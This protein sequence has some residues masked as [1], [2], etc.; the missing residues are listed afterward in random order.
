MPT[1]PPRWISTPTGFLMVLRE[2]DDVFAQLEALMVR[3]DLPS[4]SFMGFG[5]LRRATFGFYDFEQKE[6]RPQTFEQLEL[7]NMTGTLA[8]KAGKPS[9]HA[10][11]VAGD[12][13]FA[14]MGGHLLGLEVG[15]GSL[16]VTIIRHGQRLE[17]EV[18]PR[19]GANILSLG[20]A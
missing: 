17:R 18:D 8:W 14:T 19:I 9:V 3:E 15:T 13:R 2:G 11:G 20:P 6:Y 5:F 4:A 12:A 10:H 7:A 16:E 1:P